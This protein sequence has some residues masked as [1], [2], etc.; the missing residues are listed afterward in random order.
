METFLLVSLLSFIP[1]IL[2]VLFAHL[3]Q[4]QGTDTYASFLVTSLYPSHSLFSYVCKLSN[5]LSLGKK[6]THARRRFSMAYFYCKSLLVC[7]EN[8]HL[9]FDQLPSE[10]YH[11]IFSFI[12]DADTLM[13]LALTNKKLTAHALSP[14]LWKALTHSLVKSTLSP[15]RQRNI[16]NNPSETDMQSQIWHKVY[17]RMFWAYRRGSFTRKENTLNMA[18]FFV[19]FSVC[20]LVFVPIVVFKQVGGWGYFITLPILGFFL[21]VTIILFYL[22]QYEHSHINN[23]ILVSPL[24]NPHF[25]WEPLHFVLYVMVGITLIFVLAALLCGFVFMVQKDPSSIKWLQ[26]ACLEFLAIRSFLLLDSL[27]CVPHHTSLSHTMYTAIN[28]LCGVIALQ[29][30]GTDCYSPSNSLGINL[31]QFPVTYC[32]HVLFN[33][34]A[35]LRFIANEIISV[36]K[37]KYFAKK[38]PIIEQVYPVSVIVELSIVIH[39]ILISCTPTEW[40]DFVFGTC[41]SSCIKMIAQALFF[42]LG[43]VIYTVNY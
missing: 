31:L 23:P 8:V 13:S 37:M 4:Y 28:M 38:L 22:Q 35:M 36:K 15:I 21:Y 39:L 16:V 19:C 3:F 1:A 6:V 26:V 7:E 43:L 12:Q 42:I 20:I 34:I 11:H 18:Y 29:Y 32:V 9:S 14:F 33:S 25:T 30:T 10:I 41:T 40:R 17:G 27:F 24:S 5:F 2:I